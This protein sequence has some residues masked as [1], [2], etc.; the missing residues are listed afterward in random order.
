M[1]KLIA[2]ESTITKYGSNLNAR[3]LQIGFNKDDRVMEI[4]GTQYGIL[5]GWLG[6]LLV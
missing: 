2:R 1:F 3:V 5:T 4:S 6:T